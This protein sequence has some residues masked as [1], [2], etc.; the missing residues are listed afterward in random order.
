MTKSP[1]SGQTVSRLAGAGGRVIVDTHALVW[2]L[3]DPELLGTGAVEAIRSGI[4]SA[5][6]ASLWELLIKKSKP[7]ALLAEPL[8]WWARYVVGSGIRVLGIRESHV[9][10]LGGLGPYHKDPFDRILVAQAIVERATLVSKD[11]TLAQYG[12]SVVW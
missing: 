11:A 2:A 10:A 7:G 6:V 3:R 1:M 12:I 9:V 4:V 5:S 8:D